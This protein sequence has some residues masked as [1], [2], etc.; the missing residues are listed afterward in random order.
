MRTHIR[1]LSQRAMAEKKLSIKVSEL[2]CNQKKLFFKIVRKARSD[3]IK[4]L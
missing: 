1:Y 4:R 3:K 2:I